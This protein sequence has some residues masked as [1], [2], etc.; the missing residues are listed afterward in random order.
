M[1]IQVFCPTHPFDC[2]HNSL[3]FILWSWTVTL[4]PIL[5]NDNKCR[6]FFLGLPL[7]ENFSFFG[8]NQSLPV[9]GYIKMIDLW[10]IF[11]LSYPFFVITL[12]SL[13]EVL[14]SS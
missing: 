2:D 3:N 13:L 1:D 9:T 4:L 11:A 6:V 12:H 10:M 8:I 7:N 5:V 14:S